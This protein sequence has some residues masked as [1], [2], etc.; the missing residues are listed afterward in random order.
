MEDLAKRHP[1]HLRVQRAKAI[2]YTKAAQIYSDGVNDHSAA[3]TLYQSVIA[4]FEQMTRDNPRNV[5]AQDDLAVA[6]EQL[7]RMHANAG[8][9]DESAAAFRAALAIRIKLSASD[10]SHLRWQGNV[11]TLQHATGS[12][13]L[14]QGDVQAAADLFSDALLRSQQLA[15]ADPDEVSWH[16]LAA[17]SHER[18]GAVH[19]MRRDRDRAVA[20][21]RRALASMREVARLSPASADA[22][23]NLELIQQQIAMVLSDGNTPERVPANA[24]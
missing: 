11:I 16:S 22:Q 7:A 17:V 5:V 9:L 21:Y 14:A 19:R 10:P 23:R 24:R 3:L 15:N 6:Q 4:T 13:W 12:A 1:D 2:A 18:L 8:R 20:S